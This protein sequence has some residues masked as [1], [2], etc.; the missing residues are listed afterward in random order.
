MSHKCA[1]CPRKANY[2]NEYEVGT[3]IKVSYYCKGHKIEG[4]AFGFLEEKDLERI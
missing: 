4:C 1:F 2:K 3:R